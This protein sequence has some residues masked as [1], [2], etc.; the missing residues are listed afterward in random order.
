MEWLAVAAYVCVAI[1]AYRSIMA[2]HKGCFPN[3]WNDPLER[4]KMSVASIVF[5]ITWPV[6]WPVFL[7]FTGWHGFKYK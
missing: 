2:A 3:L 1:S 5:A 4:S 7:L 6:S